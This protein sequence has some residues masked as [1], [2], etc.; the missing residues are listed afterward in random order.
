MAG[1]N[2]GNEGNE[3]NVGSL[4]RAGG[5]GFGVLPDRV[6]LP[7][8][9]EGNG[10]VGRQRLRNVAWDPRFWSADWAAWLILRDFT[11]VAQLLDANPS[12]SLR[13][14]LAMGD[15]TGTGTLT[16]D[17]ATPTLA[18]VC[19]G[20]YQVRLV[21]TRGGANMFQLHAPGGRLVDEQP[22][23]VTATVQF[24]SEIKFSIADGG[25]TFVPGDTFAIR[26]EPVTVSIRDNRP[27]ISG[28]GTC[29]VVNANRP[30]RRD[31]QIGDYQVVCTDAGTKTFELSDPNGTVIDTQ[32]IQAGGA[33]FTTQVHLRLTEGTRPFATGDG[34][35]VTVRRAIWLSDPG[36]MSPGRAFQVSVTGGASNAGDGKCVLDRIPDKAGVRRGRYEVKCVTPGTHFQ[37]AHKQAGTIGNPVQ[38][39]GN[40]WTFNTELGFTIENGGT[41]FG[42]GDVFL[43]DVITAEEAELEALVRLAEDERADALGEILAQADGFVGYFMAAMGVSPRTHPKTCRLLHAASLVGAYVSLHFKAHYRRARPS[44]MAPGLMP[45]IPVPGHPAYPSG[46]ST[47]AHLMALCARAGLNAAQ[48]P[49]LGIVLDELADRIAR[50]REI[51]GLHFP[52]DSSAGATLAEAAF[53]SLDSAAMPSFQTLATEAKGEWP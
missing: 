47:Q 48:L 46:H 53:A 6:D 27:R 25:T 33:T 10:R 5:G 9:T 11:R 37:L 14:T 40:K 19:V 4:G 8:I 15:N 52:S 34:F 22:F 45:P 2:E 32:Q 1:S 29:A 18:G 7:F 35:I 24:N 49:D 28:D 50:N 21:T 13:A 36:P 20:N 42:A 44:Q 26:V 43:I 38:I 41:A 30:V 39:A 3:G 51:A 16:L 23:S 17:L 12:Q 31:A